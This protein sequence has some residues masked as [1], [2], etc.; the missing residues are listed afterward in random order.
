MAKNMELNGLIHS[1][2][3]NETEMAKAMGYSRQ[4]LNRIT[5]GKKV[6]DL[7]EVNDMAKALHKPFEVVAQFFLTKKSTTVDI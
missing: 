1:V 7:N 3:G 5:N 6:P 4:R 2:F